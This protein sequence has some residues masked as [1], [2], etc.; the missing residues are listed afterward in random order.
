MAGTVLSGVFILI[1]KSAFLLCLL[2]SVTA[3]W[4]EVADAEMTIPGTSTRVPFIVSQ[5]FAAGSLG[6]QGFGAGAA[7]VVVGGW[8]DVGGWAAWSLQSTFL[9]LNKMNS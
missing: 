5:T 4:T 1:V 7:P 9:P 2:S 3:S 6:T 8:V